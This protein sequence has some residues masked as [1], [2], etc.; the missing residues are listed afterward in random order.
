MV[1]GMFTFR[2][3]IRAMGGAGAVANA[4]LA[5][6]QRRDEEAVIEARLQRIPGSPSSRSTSA[7]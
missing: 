3:F 4:S 5:C 2:Q 1:R 7:A 6:Q